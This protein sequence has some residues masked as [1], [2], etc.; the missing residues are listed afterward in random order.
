MKTNKIN[1]VLSL[2]KAQRNET[3]SQ[4]F[5]EELRINSNEWNSYMNPDGGVTLGV[6][7]KTYLILGTISDPAH[8]K[9]AKPVGKG[10]S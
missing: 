1:V 3:L 8:D 2:N 10:I 6:T 9:Y 4:Y 7:E 5:D